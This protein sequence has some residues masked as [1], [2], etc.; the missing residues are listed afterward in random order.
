M[1]RVRT[2]R[3]IVPLS[4]GAYVLQRKYGVELRNI[5]KRLQI[6]QFG[7]SAEKRLFFGL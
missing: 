4:L 3:G 6:F 5:P 1:G 2:W 7:I